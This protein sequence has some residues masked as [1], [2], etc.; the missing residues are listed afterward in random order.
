MGAPASP[1]NRKRTPIKRTPMRRKAPAPLF[2]QWQSE[3]D[4][5]RQV[6][7]LAHVCGYMT[8]HAHLPF[9]DTAGMPDLLI[10]HPRTG[11]TI[12]A[13]LKVRDKHG[14]APKPG[15]A[16]SRWLAALAIKNETYL[17]LWPDSWDEL[18]KVLA[19]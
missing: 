13:E 5:Q 10:V 7:E 8:S 17:W 1:D 9:F 19:A 11:R 4:F 14:H 15:P 2:V 18:E 3:A 16:Q 12:F 6:E